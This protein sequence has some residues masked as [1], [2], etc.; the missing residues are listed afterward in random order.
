MRT[1]VAS[2]ELWRTPISERSTGLNAM[3]PMRAAYTPREDGDAIAA[4]LPNATRRTVEGQNHGVDQ[5]VLA[6]I[7]AEWFA[8]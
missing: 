5:Q 7:L 6:P 2:P 8:A 1:S 3:L 4:L